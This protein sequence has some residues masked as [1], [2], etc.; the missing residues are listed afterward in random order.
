VEPLTEVSASIPI[1]YG[2]I[3]AFPYKV[4]LKYESWRD[5]EHLLKSGAKFS[6][7]SDHPVTLQRNIF[8]SFRHLLRFGPS[9]ADAISKITKE[10]AEIIGA[11]CSDSEQN[12]IGQIRPGFKA[13][14]VVWNGDPFLLSS[15][16]IL[17]IA[18]GKKVYEE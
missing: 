12:K 3:D 9:K 6:I 17:V 2:P 5:A 10:P 7:M 11:V 16:P 14:L 1:I 15:Y 4:E 8:Y 18:E 13:S